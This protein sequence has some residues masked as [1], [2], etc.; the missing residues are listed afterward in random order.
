MLSSRRLLNLIEGL[1]DDSR[2][3]TVVERDG[4]FTEQEIW[5][6][7]IFNEL[8]NMHHTLQA[9]NADPEKWEDYDP[10]RFLSRL[11]RVAY[12]AEKTAESDEDQQAFD[13]FYAEMGWD[14]D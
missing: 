3:K 6:M 8:A 1:R 11:E 9:V 12:W 5:Q 14:T 4:E 10:P 7:R 13:D 2:Y